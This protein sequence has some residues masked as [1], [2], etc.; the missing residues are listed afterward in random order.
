[1]PLLGLSRK[2]L[3][4]HFQVMNGTK[5]PRQGNSNNREATGAE[6]DKEYL[7]ERYEGLDTEELQR[8]VLLGDGLEPEARVVLAEVL[9]RR[10]DVVPE[11]VGAVGSTS[12]HEDVFPK[13]EIPT[14]ALGTVGLFIGALVGTAFVEVLIGSIAFGGRAPG[15]VRV[16]IWGVSIFAVSRLFA[17][18][19][20]KERAYRK[21]G[22][23]GFTELMYCAAVGEHDTARR[24]IAAGA[25]LNEQASDGVT[26]LMMA[27]K[28]KQHELIDLLLEH[29]AA[30][31]VVAKDGSTALSLAKEANHA[32]LEKMK[33][34]SGSK[35]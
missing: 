4:S 1:M 28:M 29:G 12:V 33:A 26:A 5:I 24:L 8:L 6:M 9:A 30:A 3:K 16:G 19:R 13:V 7:R 23:E 15:I 32:A 27:V 34:A 25:N 2:E 20:M 14:S 10:G 22:K 11:Q 18:R 35:G 31:N 17:L 21:I